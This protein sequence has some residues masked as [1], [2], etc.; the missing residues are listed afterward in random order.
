MAKVIAMVGDIFF[1]A[2]ISAAAKQVGVALEYAGN[3][4]VLMEKAKSNPSLII[5]DLNQTSSQPLDLIAKLKSD[6]ALKEIP[7]VGFLSHV[8]TDLAAAAK[9][10]GCDQV[11]PRS[12]FSANLP[13]ILQKGAAG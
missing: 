8:Q 2:K 1:G 13:E 9:Q 3:E 12:A 11:M 5:F 4:A 10:A 6:A 7:V